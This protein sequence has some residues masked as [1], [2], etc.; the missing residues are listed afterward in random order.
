MPE[1]D[2]RNLQKPVYIQIKNSNLPIIQCFHFYY[3]LGIIPDITKQK[4]VGNCVSNTL[5][6][7]FSGIKLPDAVTAPSLFMSKQEAVDLKRERVSEQS[8]L[9]R[10]KHGF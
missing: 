8:K 1:K 3:G 7:Q 9:S 4:W 6:Q 2:K 5:F 10:L